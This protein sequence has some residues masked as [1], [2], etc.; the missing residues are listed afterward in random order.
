VL[1]AHIANGNQFSLAV[2]DGHAKQ[3]LAQENTLSV[4]AKSTVMEV[5]EKGFR[6]IKPIVNR[7]VVLSLSA[8]YPR[9]ALCVLKR[10]RHD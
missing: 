4:V 5:G 3:P 9:A 2:L 6:L 10:V 1:F 8:E 7:D